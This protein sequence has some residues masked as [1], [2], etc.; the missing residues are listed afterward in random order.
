MTIRP[1]SGPLSAASRMKISNRA[2]TAPNP[3]GV[4]DSGRVHAEGRPPDRPLP[5][6]LRPGTDEGPGPSRRETVGRRI[7]HGARGHRR[8]EGPRPPTGPRRRKGVS[9]DSVEE[10]GTRP[11]ACGL[12][13]DL[14]RPKGGE[15]DQRVPVA[16]ITD[17]PGRCGHLPPRVYRRR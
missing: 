9:V 14:D 17:G 4:A 6:I 15:A 2:E 1:E 8:G 5:R 11:R 12:L 3:Y 13:Q 16:A 10:R 7:P